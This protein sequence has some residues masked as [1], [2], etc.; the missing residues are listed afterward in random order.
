MKQITVPNREM[1]PECT[2]G[3]TTQKF[4]EEWP[5]CLEEHRRCTGCGVEYILNY[6]N[7]TLLEREDNQ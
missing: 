2:H 5:D 1:C 4:I 6:D 7:P 3:S